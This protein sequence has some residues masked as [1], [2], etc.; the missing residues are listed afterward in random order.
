MGG[1]METLLAAS[2]TTSI[3]FLLPFYLLSS[4][5]PPHSRMVCPCTI[6]SRASASRSTCEHK[7]C[8]PNAL[9]P[10]THTRPLYDHPPL[11]MDGGHVI[12]RHRFTTPSK[13][14]YSTWLRFEPHANWTRLCY[15]MSR[16]IGLYR[17]EF[18]PHFH[19]LSECVYFAPL[20]FA[21]L[22]H[23][24]ELF[25]SFTLHFL[26][27]FFGYI[28]YVALYTYL[29]VSIIPPFPLSSLS[30]LLPPFHSHSSSTRLL[31]AGSLLP[32]PHSH[33]PSLAHPL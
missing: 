15:V 20:H 2:S 1:L 10:Y 31:I 11:P 30:L 12:I 17:F 22:H 27:L 5:T 25:A 18:I 14:L 3:S 23:T 7:P 9:H 13:L 4:S 29:I 19:F 26:G 33:Y 21:S 24:F 6:P 32:H 16:L 8:K 28:R